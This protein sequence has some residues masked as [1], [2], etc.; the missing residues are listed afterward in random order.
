MDRLGK[1][2]FAH[3]PGIYT[4]IFFLIFRLMRYTDGCFFHSRAYVPDTYI[5]MIRTLCSRYVCTWYQPA[6]INTY[7]RYVPPVDAHVWRQLHV[8]AVARCSD[9]YCIFLRVHFLTKLAT[10]RL[11]RLPYDG[12]IV[13]LSKCIVYSYPFQ[14]YLRWHRSTKYHELWGISPNWCNLTAHSPYGEFPK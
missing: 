13:L 9:S 11:A 4:N 2:W 6:E 10:L 8:S 12:S 5:R 14:Q 3:V 1:I 7:V